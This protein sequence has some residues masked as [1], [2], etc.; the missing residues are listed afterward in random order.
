MPESIDTTPLPGTHANEMSSAES[1]CLFL[2]LSCR[3]WMISSL[4]NVGKFD[5]I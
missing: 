4:H 1:F 3:A 5:K 2:D